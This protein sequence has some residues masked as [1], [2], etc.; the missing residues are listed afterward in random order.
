MPRLLAHWQHETV[1]DEA[2]E[3]LEESNM[4]KLHLTSEQARA[5]FCFV[6][7]QYI[8]ST[9]LCNCPNMPDHSVSDLTCDNV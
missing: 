9:A 2:L 3:L 7:V 5:A 8:T 4:I 1:D 6:Q